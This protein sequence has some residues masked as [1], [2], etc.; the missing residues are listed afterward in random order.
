[1]QGIVFVITVQIVFGFLVPRSPAFPTHLLSKDIS[2]LI[3]S[4]FVLPYGLVT[5]SVYLNLFVFFCMIIIYAA[6]VVPF[7]T[8]ELRLGS[9]AYRSNS[10]LRTNSAEICIAY[11][12]VYILQ[13][14]VNISVGKI[15]IPAYF[16]T[17]L[18]PCF[19]LF[20]LIKHRE[21]VGLATI[22]LLSVWA[23]LAPSAM[24]VI[25][26]TGGYLNKKGIK[27]LNSW[28]FHENS[29]WKSSKERRE[30][31]KFRKS[32]K[33]I[34]LSQ[35]NYYRITKISILLFAKNLCKALVKIL[36]TLPEDN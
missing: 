1:M 15:L 7:I 14:A 25:L 34:S 20:I 3:L 30:M 36:I 24:C 10:A 28:K 9:K 17:T 21:R 13:R 19:S 2:L 12:S 18:I 33:P 23:L 11:R 32:C 26:A 16:I 27:L 8:K 29:Q 6:F 5:I 4:P 31:K 22:L 35:G